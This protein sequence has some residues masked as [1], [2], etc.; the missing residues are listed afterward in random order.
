MN[1]RVFREYDIRGLSDTEL[2]DDFVADLGRAAGTHLKR[3]GSRRFVLG[4]DCRL[5]SPR[6]HAAFLRGLLETGAQVIDVGVVPTPVLY[7]AAFHCDADGG[8]QITGSHNPPEYNGFKVLRGKTTIF[9]DEIQAL[10][11]LVEARDFDLAPGGQVEEQDVLGPYI[12]HVAGGIHMGPRRFKVVVDAGNGTG[13]VTCVPILQKLGFDVT[14]LYCEMD[15]RFPNHHPDPTVE[16]NV[17][18]LRAMVKR[19]KAE[20]GIALDGDA[21]RIG[22]VDSRGRMV[23]G[24]QL[25]ILFARE[26]LKE[27]PGATFVSE[28]KASKTLYDDIAQHGGRAIMWKVGHSLIKSKMKEEHAL[29][30]GEMSG[31]MFFAHRYLG[32]DD[33]VYAAVRLVEMLS[34][35]GETLADH[36]DT[37]PRTFNTPEIRVEVPEEVKFEVVRRA[38]EYFRARHEIV[39]VDGVRILFPDGW[40]LIRASNTQPCLVLRF[41]AATQE[42]LAEIR[43]EIEARLRDIEAEAEHEQAQP[44]A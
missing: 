9:S 10:R 6:L 29:L 30:A 38:T 1:P 43:R 2:T 13:G 35:S 26:I 11:R 31:H 44:P 42:R 39:D 20:L 15:G 18:D 17:A 33:A 21:D 32:Y 19:E 41:E 28:V 8:A 7:F 24:D 3:H 25:M 4:R 27:Q 14:P 16:A 36:V 34:L 12:G 37:L 23:W 40:G 22:V 5:S